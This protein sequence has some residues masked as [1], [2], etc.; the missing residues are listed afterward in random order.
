LQ[1]PH[2]RYLFYIL[3]RHR[4]L[5]QRLV[6]ELYHLHLPL[7]QLNNLLMLAQLAQ[8]LLAMSRIF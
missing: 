1:L 3:Q 4:L 8:K 5:R 6:L 7:Q 2:I